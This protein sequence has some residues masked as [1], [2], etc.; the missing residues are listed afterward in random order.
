MEKKVLFFAI[1]FTL[2]MSGGN[3]VGEPW[4]FLEGRYL[5]RGYFD[6]ALDPLTR[7]APRDPLVNLLYDLRP[8]I[9]R[10]KY[11]S[12]FASYGTYS[13]RRFPGHYYSM[14][15]HGLHSRSSY[16]DY[17]YRNAYKQTYFNYNSQRHYY[18]HKLYRTPSAPK[19]LLYLNHRGF[20]SY[21]SGLSFR[22]NYR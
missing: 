15:Y 21:K 3:A 18:D 12:F 6:R 8:A 1:V 5:D 7:L 2:L 17:Y 13:R 14:G 10:I 20:T 16:H 9:S 22:V 19:Y 11:R 4:Y